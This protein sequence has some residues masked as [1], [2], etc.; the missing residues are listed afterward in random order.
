[1]RAVART[2]VFSM[3]GH[4]GAYAWLWDTPRSCRVAGQ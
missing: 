1:V 4:F 2:A 3:N